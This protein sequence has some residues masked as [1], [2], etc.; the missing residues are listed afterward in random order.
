MRKAI[1][2]RQGA[3]T[4][5]TLIRWLST[6]SLALLAPYVIVVILDA[7]TVATAPPPAPC[8]TLRCPQTAA[9]GTATALSLTCGCLLAPTLGGILAGALA[10]L[11]GIEQAIRSRQGFWL[12]GL[13]LAGFV[14]VAPILVPAVAS[15]TGNTGADGRPM[16]PFGITPSWD[17]G[18][19]IL[20]VPL[21]AI[22]TA[23]V[24]LLFA[25]VGVAM[26]ARQTAQTVRQRETGEEARV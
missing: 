9:F 15:A 17:Q 2:A 19:D 3:E 10:W 13:L 12:I 4:N 7:V 26:P 18:W 16:L 24:T 20:S 25:I 8:H 14:A 21:L 23:L 11:Q 22:P 6:V 1:E 5:A